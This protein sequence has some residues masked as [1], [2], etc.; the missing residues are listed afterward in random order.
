M[1]ILRSAVGG[2]A[3]LM[4]G[5]GAAVPA[6]HASEQKEEK[7]DMVR[8][9]PISFCCVCVRLLLFWYLHPKCKWSRHSSHQASKILVT[10]ALVHASGFQAF[11]RRLFC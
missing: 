10:M 2:V 6:P 4:F 3:G 1:N 9:V 8:L 11:V 5:G 7:R